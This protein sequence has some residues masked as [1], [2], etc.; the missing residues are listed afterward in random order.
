MS[1]RVSI[2]RVP[3]RKFFISTVRVREVPVA[4]GC[5]S[6]FVPSGSASQRSLVAPSD[7]NGA[8]IA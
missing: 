3:T 7:Q 8:L 6:M 5:T 1:R 4:V 2:S